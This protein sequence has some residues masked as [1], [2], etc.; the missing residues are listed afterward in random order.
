MHEFKHGGL[1]SSSGQKVKVQE[2]GDSNRPVGKWTEQRQAVKEADASPRGEDV[3]EV[4]VSR[5]YEAETK[6]ALSDIIPA[7]AK[8]VTCRKSGKRGRSLRKV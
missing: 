1:K 6:E 7:D 4:W 2:A 8:A 3:E 5:H